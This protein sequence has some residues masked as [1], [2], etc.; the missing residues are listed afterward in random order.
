VADD[1]ELVRPVGAPNIAIIVIKSAFE[2]FPL[3]STTRG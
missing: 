3:A 1:L 2:V